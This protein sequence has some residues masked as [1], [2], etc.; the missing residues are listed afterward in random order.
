VR[1]TIPWNEAKTELENLAN[2]R[3]ALPMFEPTGETVDIGQ[4]YNR[5]L[6]LNAGM[7]FWND[8]RPM[9]G[10]SVQVAGHDLQVL[11]HS[12]M[13]E[14]D[15]L[16]FVRDRLGHVSTLHACLNVHN[17]G[18]EVAQ[19][20]IEHQRGRLITRARMV[21]RFVSS[22]KQGDV[23]RSGETFYIGSPKSDEW[24]RV[25]DKG[26]EQGLSADWIRAEVVWHGKRA[27]A[28]HAQMLAVGIVAVT[29]SAIL[30]MA[31]CDLPWWRAATAGELVPPLTLPPKP[32]NRYKWLRFDVLPV[33]LNEI[34]EERR[35]GNGD[36]A[37]IYKNALTEV[38]PD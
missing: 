34:A 31:S 10:V 11:R 2:A 3:P 27:R 13:S 1:Y 35:T 22:S 23:W 7:I 16:H 32:S 14:T 29:R 37:T 19:L 8:T 30:H 24:M 9:Q 36:I 28:A 33:L 6:R 20:V 15:L 26:A 21:G 12:E 17:S 5:G 25:Y 4:G 18:G 38:D